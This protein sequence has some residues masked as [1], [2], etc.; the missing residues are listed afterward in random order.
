MK[1]KENSTWELEIDEPKKDHDN[2]KNQPGPYVCPIKTAK[3]PIF[4]K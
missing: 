1:N 2:Y 4:T 3:R